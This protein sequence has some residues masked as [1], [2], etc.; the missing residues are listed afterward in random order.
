MSSLD[1]IA[2]QPARVPVKFSLSERLIRTKYL[3]LKAKRVYDRSK[4]LPPRSKAGAFGLWWKDLQTRVS[5]RV[6]EKLTQIHKLY[7]F[8]MI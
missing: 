1:K 4:R 3:C 6:E 2:N 8:Q 5:L 7:S